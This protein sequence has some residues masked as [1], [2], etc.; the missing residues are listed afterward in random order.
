MKTPKPSPRPP[1]PTPQTP[2]SAI[3]HADTWAHEPKLGETVVQVRQTAGYAAVSCPDNPAC[4][5]T[6]AQQATR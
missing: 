1:D 4:P 2:P 6:L 5:A 3:D